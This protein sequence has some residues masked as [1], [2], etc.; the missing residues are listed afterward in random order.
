M[1]LNDHLLKIDEYLEKI[2]SLNSDVQQNGMMDQLQADLARQ[3]LRDLYELYTALG[4]EGES[5]A[6][7]EP[8]PRE[9][10]VAPVAVTTAEPPAGKEQAA[11]SAGPSFP[12]EPEEQPVE[13]AVQEE[14]DEVISLLEKFRQEDPAN[15]LNRQQ[16]AGRQFREL[17]PLNEKIM[18]TREFFDNNISGYEAAIAELDKCTSKSEVLD[19]MQEHAWTDAVMEQQRE[20]IDRFV[21]IIDLKYS[22]ESS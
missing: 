13:Q 12:A 22:A 15:E 11:D 2:R 6:T 14:A 16:V 5:A 20:L 21:S 1:S 4:R 3:Y 19:Y 18:F 10:E 17:I 7:N 8:E 9:A